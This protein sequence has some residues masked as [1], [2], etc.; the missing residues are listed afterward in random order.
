MGGQVLQHGCDAGISHIPQSNQADKICNVPK[1][2][3]FAGQ[4]AGQGVG[5]GIDLPQFWCLCEICTELLGSLDDEIIHQIGFLW[6]LGF[7]VV[8]DE[9]VHAACCSGVAFR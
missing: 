5:D 6:V 4:N 3:R 8:C 7:D 1:E 2:F 9:A